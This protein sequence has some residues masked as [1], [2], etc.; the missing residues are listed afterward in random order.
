MKSTCSA[1][2]ELR[3]SQTIVWRVLRRRLV[4]RPYHLQLVQALRANDKVKRVEFC[5][6]MPKN[7]EDEL[8]PPRV[9]FSDEATF[10]LSGKVNRHNVRIWGLQDT[11]VTLEYVR[12]SPKVNVFRAISLTKVYGPFFFRSIG[13]MGNEDLTLQFWPPGSPDLTPCDFFLWGFVKDAVYVPPLPTGLIDL[14]N[15]ITAA[16]NS[17]TQ[18]ICHQVWDEFSN[19][20]DV[21]GAA[22]G[23]HIEHL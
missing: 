9:I 6:R 5:D 4:Y 19:C 20:L 15:H 18:D 22:G 10:H 1:S 12:D 17:V 8:F 3:L 14:R 21:I 23:G 11:H 7:M 16:V 2:R 13:R